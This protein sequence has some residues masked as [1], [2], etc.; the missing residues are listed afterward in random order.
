M[1]W[2]N[3]KMHTHMSGLLTVFVKSFLFLSCFCKRKYIDALFRESPL[4]LLLSC[5][6]TWFLRASHFLIYRPLLWFCS[7]TLLAFQSS[8]ERT[9]RHISLSKGSL[10]PW[11]PQHRLCSLMISLWA[12]GCLSLFYRRF[13]RYAGISKKWTTGKSPT[14]VH[15]FIKQTFIHHLLLIFFQK[16][17]FFP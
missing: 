7:N 2:G 16:T 17:S 6:L 14:P 9:R 5:Y 11:P 8:L 12:P 15:S 1:H 13:T 3:F 4:I 10:R